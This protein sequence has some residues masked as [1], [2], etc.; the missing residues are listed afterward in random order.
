MKMKSTLVIVW[1][2]ALMVLPLANVSHADLINGDFSDELN[3]WTTEGFY[4]P[5]GDVRV[6]NGEAILGDNSE[7]WSALYQPIALDPIKYTIAFDFKNNLSNEL[8]DSSELDDSS[9]V[10]Y[11]IFFA[12]LYFINDVSQFNLDIDPALNVFDDSSP[13]FDMEASG[14][15]NNNGIIG[16]SSKGQEW[17]HFSTT[18]TNTYA[19]VIPTFE[20]LDF[21]YIND[22]SQVLIANVGINPVPEPTTLLLLGSG[23]FALAGMARKRRKS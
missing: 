19:Y 12:S 5:E 11:D 13:L 10:F 14:V 17:L 1:T 2:L 20:L 22:D 23:L 18:F 6:V 4:F 3:G 16:T 7:I 9:F 8:Y 15:S 21:N